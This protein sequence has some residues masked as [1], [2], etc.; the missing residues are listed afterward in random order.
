MVSDPLSQLTAVFVPSGND[1]P[2]T[3]CGSLSVLGQV[4]GS[5]F[6]PLSLGLPPCTL[7]FMDKA[8]AGQ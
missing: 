2:S 1:P 5:V 7:Y 6:L 4:V 3:H 8:H